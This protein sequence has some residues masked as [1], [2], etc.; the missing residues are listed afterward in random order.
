MSVGRSE[1][2]V[3]RSAPRGAVFISYAREDAVAAD[4]IAEALRSHGLEVWFDQ[5]ELRGGDTW[6]QK[7]RGQI[8]TCALF[9]PIVS[10]RTQERTEG[11]F[12]REWKLAVERTADMADGMAFLIPVAIDDTR[13][14]DALVP[15]AFMRYQWTRLANGV[16]TPQFVEQVKHLL[17]G[18][19]KAAPKVEPGR[20]RLERGGSEFATAS[21]DREG[22]ASPAKSA[23]VGRAR[24]ARPLVFAIAAALVVAA[25]G[26]WIFLR[27]DPSAAEA[28]ARRS[29]P[30]TA[31]KSAAAGK[32]IAVLPFA[33]MSQAKDQEYFSDGLSEELLNLLAKV[34][35]LQVTSRS[36]AFSF[37]GKDT[38]LSQIAREL[39][40]AHIL[41]GSV[42]R[43]G[44]RLR[45][46]AQ[47]IDAGTDKHLWSETYDRPLDDIFAVQDDIARAVVAQLKV[48]LLGAVPQTKAADPK[49]YALF[50]HARQLQR[51]G[52]V[53]GYE[54]ALALYQQALEA[55]R[56]L[57]VAWVGMAETYQIIAGLGARD[58][59]GTYQLG[60]EAV[61]KAL[62]IDPG[63]AS[64]HA[65][66]GALA[67][68]QDGDLAAAA[69]HLEHALALEPAN[70]DILSTAMLV[71]RSLDRL[72]Q[73]VAIGE[74]LVAHDPVDALAHLRLGAACMRVG[75][76]DDGAVALRA[77]LRLA[78]NRTQTHFNLGGGLL[79]K[80]DARNALAE[81]R[82]EPAE[83]WRLG[84]LAMAHHALGEKAESDAA[85]ADMI[86]KYEKSAAWNI[87][88]V[89]AFR[90]EIDGAFEWLE[91]ALVY[92][93]PGVGDTPSMPYFGKAI[94]KDP[95]WL[96]FLRKIKRAPEQL[97]PIK[98]N[99]KLPGR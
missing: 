92:G 49:A 45:I 22:A 64:G 77:A 52:S 72:E 88:Y 26:G 93:D 71:L 44:N 38:K 59:D 98:F 67:R 96:Q 7:I 99:V 69:R 80:G 81:M 16:P 25:I 10:G 95:R 5:N 73:A 3:D 74:Y 85:L 37:K 97:A 18:S 41:E 4:R 63:L 20:P 36:S 54:Q 17:D 23:E 19:K 27:P 90:G 76:Y 42:R 11:Y 82:Q 9:V 58:I 75:R 13:E 83:M 31:G 40:V 8:K 62:A 24:R 56:T 51:Q 61:N 2:G 84:G 12:R 1:S 47:L 30:P 15:E 53:A 32:S 79:L 91:K 70:S 87:A 55:D 48:T 43:A 66:L 14:D 78:P 35:G 39:N 50:L 86:A 94:A 28:V 6:D 21:P 65:A 60:R 34:P 29:A 68:T 33:D 89:R 57:A 46:T